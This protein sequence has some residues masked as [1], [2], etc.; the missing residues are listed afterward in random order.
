ML[1]HLDRANISG[2]TRHV[3]ATTDGRDWSFYYFDRDQFFLR[4]RVAD[5]DENTA[6]ILGISSLSDIP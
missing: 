5:T 3:G 4:K 1:D 6:H 2:T